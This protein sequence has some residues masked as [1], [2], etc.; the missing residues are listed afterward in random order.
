MSDHVFGAYHPFNDDDVMPS[1]FKQAI[2]ITI[3]FL[4]DKSC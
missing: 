1:D 4:K 2:D 3:K